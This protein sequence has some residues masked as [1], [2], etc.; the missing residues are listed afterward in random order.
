M[1]YEDSDFEAD[2]NRGRLEQQACVLPGRL[3]L[4]SVISTV[5]SR[6]ERK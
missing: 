5:E 4:L 3:L 1:G 6:I 2:V